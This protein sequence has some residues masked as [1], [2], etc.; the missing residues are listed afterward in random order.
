[1]NKNQVVIASILLVSLSSLLYIF[2]DSQWLIIRDIVQIF[3]FPFAFSPL[4]INDV[5]KK[6]NKSEWVSSGISGIL[7]TFI[8]TSAMSIISIINLLNNGQK[9]L[10]NLI[11]VGA[12]PANTN[13][14]DFTIF[15]IYAICVNWFFEIMLGAFLGIISIIVFRKFLDSIKK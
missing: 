11:K 3:I 12:F 9:A 10:N 2:F 13:I 14:D 7:L 15:N 1:M 4:I 6:I 8:P 5:Q